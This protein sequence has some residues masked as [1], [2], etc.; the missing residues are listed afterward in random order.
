LKLDLPIAEK[1]RPDE[2]LDAFD[3]VNGR[4]GAPHRREH[5]AKR[6]ALVLV[7]VDLQNLSGA[8]ETLD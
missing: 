2:L 6:R 1:T 3:E 5:Q 8:P 4:A 7:P